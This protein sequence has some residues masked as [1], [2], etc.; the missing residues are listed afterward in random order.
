MTALHLDQHISFNQSAV[1]SSVQRHQSGTRTSLFR[2]KGGNFHSFSRLK[3]SKIQ[4]EEHDSG[5]VLAPPP[6]LDATAAGRDSV[7][8][9]S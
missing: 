8:S 6:V 1:I 2:H 7:A 3:K 9:R 4:Q 5:A